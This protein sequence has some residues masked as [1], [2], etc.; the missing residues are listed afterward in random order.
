LEGLRR[1][2]GIPDDVLAALSPAELQR[3]MA[4]KNSGQT[5]SNPDTSDHGQDKE[6]N[7]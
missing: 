6:H 7:D 3:A 5:P 2:L 1:E 4:R